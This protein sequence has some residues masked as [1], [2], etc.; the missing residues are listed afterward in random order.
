MYLNTTDKV[1]KIYERFEQLET[2]DR[3]KFTIYILDKLNNNLINERN[4]VNP[5]TTDEDFE[6]FNFDTFGMNIN[7]GLEII[8]YLINILK[9]YVDE[10]IVYSN[11]LIIVNYYDIK[12]LLSNFEKLSFIEK[13][14]VVEELLIRYDNNTLLNDRELII[15]SPDVIYNIEFY[16]K[17]LNNNIT[18]PYEVIN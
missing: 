3:I 12:K 17:K 10:N 9:D 14:D 5:S 1:K 4:E 18:F 7:D 16:K 15:K 13:I 6:I 8:Y 11:H 2:K